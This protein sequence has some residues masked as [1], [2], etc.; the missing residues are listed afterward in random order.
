MG[1]AD[2]VLADLTIVG[3]VYEALAKRH[4]HSRRLCLRGVAAEVVLRLLRLNTFGIG[5][6]RY[7]SAKFAPTWC[8]GTLPGS[9]ARRSRTRRRWGGGV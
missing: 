7:W 3:E 9:A 5:V 1:H 8:I 4:A 2:D 6:M